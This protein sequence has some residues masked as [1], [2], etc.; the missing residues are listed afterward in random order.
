MIYR[1]FGRTELQ[2]PVFSCGGMRYQYK[3]QD[4]P[5]DEVPE[6]NQDN[7]EKTILR[8][9]ELGI[10]HIETARGYGSSERQLGLVL[11][12]LPREKIVV[13]TKVQPTE[14]PAEF[15]QHV[16]ESLERLQLDHVDLLGLHGLNNH[17]SLWYAIRPGGCLAAARDLQ[18]EG[19]IR[20]VGFSTHG[21]PDVVSQAVQ[22]DGEGGFD[23]VNLHWYY[24]YQKNWPAIEQATQRDM[25]VFIISP[26]NK[27]G[28][29][30]EPPEK[31][32]ELCKP[33]HPLVFN[34]LWCLSHPQIHTLSI[35]AAKP[36][37]F[38]L[39]LTTLDLLD[40]AEELL[41]PIDQRLR[42]AMVEA[43]GEDV[44]DRYDEGLDHWEETNGMVN[45]PMILWLRNL[46][47][48]WGLVE[49]AAMRY[50]LLGN[51]GTW[52]AGLHARYLDDFDITGSIRNSPFADQIPGWL[53]EAQQLL[54]KK[55]EKRLSQ[56]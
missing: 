30:Y 49:Y 32:V 5:L 21:P 16:H 14:D 2:M 8:A 44:A 10:N 40:G 19:K 52:F 42:A 18:K 7:L 22:W 29:L 56:S 23:Y 1:R 48:G 54:Y 37:D 53:A 33:L 47:L 38:D 26:G 50:N 20:H 34:C 9:V 13:Q 41:P 46:A 36:G 15:V 43:V 17:R 4:V 35:G 45:V 28:M 24:I 6:D 11:P 55:P 25:G 12:K 39:Q 51:G 31:M 3:W 27:G